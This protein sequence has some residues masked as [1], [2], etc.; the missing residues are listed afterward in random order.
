MKS[1]CCQIKVEQD[2]LLRF[3]EGEYG[4]G[5]ATQAVLGREIDP[6]AK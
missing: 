2:R 1:R 5:A 6:Y 4:D 3:I